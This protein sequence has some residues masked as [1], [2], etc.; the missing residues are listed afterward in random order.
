PARRPD[1]LRSPRMKAQLADGDTGAEEALGLRER[2][3]QQ[4]RE[5]IIRVALELFDRQGFAATT[6][7]EIA[8]AADV[9]PRTVSSY[10]P[11][12]EDL[13]FPDSHAT[14]ERL[15]A[16]FDARTAGETTAEALRAW[17]TAE[18]ARWREQEE[19]S[20][21]QRRVIA[22]D[23][24]LQAYSKRFIADGETLVAKAIAEDLGGSPD[25]LEAR[26]ASAATL[27]IFGV[28]N[29]HEDAPETVKGRAPGAGSH[30]PHSRADAVELLDRALLFVSAGIRALQIARA[31][32]L[33]T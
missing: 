19:R 17:I 8:D 2:K 31:E 29:A 22:A 14:F 13:V 27:A 4:T 12:K 6:I 18:S 24:G 11:A 30:T 21:L 33:G 9:S 7:P 3:K 25:D 15:A 32:E 1:P 10:F 20:A 16:R 5:A 23:P 28:I 26:M